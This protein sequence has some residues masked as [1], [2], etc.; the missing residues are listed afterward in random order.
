MKPD[1]EVEGSNDFVFLSSLQ[2]DKI[3][4]ILQC[5]SAVVLLWSVENLEN[6]PYVKIMGERV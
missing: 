3:V 4:I 2:R 6:H 1:D 5:T